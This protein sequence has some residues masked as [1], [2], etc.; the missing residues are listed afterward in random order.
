MISG[1]FKMRE[2]RAM[3]YHKTM[4]VAFFSLPLLLLCIPAACRSPSDRQVSYHEIVSS[5]GTTEVRV[6]VHDSPGSDLVL[7][8]V[9]DD[10]NTAVEAGLELIRQYGGTLTHLQHGGTRMI[11]FD[12]GETRFTFDP[13]R[14][15]TDQ[16][17][18]HTL[19]KNGPF[20]EQ[21]L[22][23]VRSFADD[24]L[25][26]CRFEQLS[27]VVTL[28]NNHDRG[29]SAASYGEGS[30]YEAEALKVHLEA[31]IDIDDFFFVTDNVLFDFFRAGR[32]NVVLQDNEHVTDDGSL[33]VL[34]GRRGIPYVNVE[35]ERGHLREQLEMV[36]AVY[37]FYGN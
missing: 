28:H 21:A 8:N 4:R 16:G 5:I 31:G 26:I 32:F 14:M 20:S 23:Q 18:R 34:A 3:Q 22:Q 15:F 36:R 12:I 17:A 9:H 25:S 2:D 6:G 33:S 13:N 11:T 30:L 1:N 7:I 24:V 37:S 19:K 35:A 10:E 29:Y 27:L